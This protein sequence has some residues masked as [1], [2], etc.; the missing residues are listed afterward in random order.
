MG[1]DPVLGLS[2][3]DEE[4]VVR[5]LQHTYPGLGIAGL[6]CGPAPDRDVY[7]LTAYFLAPEQ[8]L[9]ATIYRLKVAA[10]MGDRAMAHELS[11]AVKNLMRLRADGLEP[12]VDEEWEQRA[13]DFADYLIGYRQWR[14]G[15][16]GELLPVS[17][18][19][20]SA[21]AAWDGDRPVHAG[22]CQYHGHRSPT[23]GC[24]CGFN[25]YAAPAPQWEHRDGPGLY[26][27]GLFAPHPH[28]QGIVWGAVRGW[29][30]MEVHASGDYGPG[31][32]SE[33]AQPVV[34][35]ARH[36]QVVEYREPIVLPVQTLD[37][38]AEMPFDASYAYVDHRRVW[39]LDGTPARRV[40]ER[41]PELQW[42]H[43]W[44]V[45][46]TAR[47]YGAELPDE[48]LPEPYDPRGLRYLVNTT[49]AVWD[50]RNTVNVR[51]VINPNP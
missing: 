48:L 24:G 51:G 45:R 35:A 8:K 10:S 2:W 33:W 49:S 17:M 15:P 42:E 18:S 34:L 27:R 5:Q 26:S 19:S 13:P 31:Y 46:R 1:C 7:L 32:R 37:Y 47:S 9:Q 3:R 29:G 50:M 25:T 14:I 28:D 30:R 16:D 36:L 4:Q 11:V 21:L 43:P 44:D 40:A 23:P 39:P 20:S 38:T 6:H 22:R 12:E 41:Y